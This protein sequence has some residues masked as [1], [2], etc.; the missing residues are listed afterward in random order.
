MDFPP[1]ILARNITKE[2]DGREVVKKINFT[3]YRGECFGILGPN[4][5]GKTTIVKMIFGL[6]PP[7][8]GELRV[9]GLKV[10]GNYR[11]I[12]SSLGVVSQ[13]DN[14]DPDLT[15]WENMDVFARYYGLH[16]NRVRPHLQEL[17]EIMGLSSY[18]RHRVEELSG[19]M[20][21]RLAIAR[22]LINKPNLLILDEPTT[23][24][25]PYARHKVWQILR[26]IKEKKIAM[27]LTTHYLEEASKLCDRLMIMDEGVIL[28]EGEPFYL[29]EKHVGKEVLEISL[30]GEP[31]SFMEMVSNHLGKL[32]K[33]YLLLGDSFYLYTWEGEKLLEEINKMAFPFSFRLLRPANLEDVFLKLTG[34]RLEG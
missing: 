18:A 11:K 14:L 23:G 15:V 6:S 3:V 20:K 17:L 31:K 13:D 10:E 8:S 29:V 1:I 12:K 19:G 27:L 25:D 9:F 28:D 32:L 7:T 24:L 4:G 30:K 33:G 5:A 34:K 22:G 26:E 21:R 2:Y 16:L